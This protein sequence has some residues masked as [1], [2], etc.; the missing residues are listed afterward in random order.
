MILGALISAGLPVE[1]LR[2]S[3]SQL[4]V[5]NFSISTRQVTKRGIRA[6]YLQVISKHDKRKH[7]HIK[8]IKRILKESRISSQVKDRAMGI[9]NN[10]AEAEARVH[11]VKK[12][13]I[14]FHELGAVDT[15]VDIVGSVIGIDFFGIDAVY[16]SDLP[17]GRGSVDIRHGKFPLP[18]PAVVELLKGV[19]VRGVDTER[20]LVTP[21]GAA[22]LK[23]LAAGFGKIPEMMIERTGYGAGDYDDTPLPD[24]LRVLIGKGRDLNTC[25]WVLETNID[26][27]NPQL[28][29]STM[30]AL[31]K[32]GALD[33]FITPVIMKKSRPGF[34]LTVLVE[35]KKKERVEE[36]IFQ[37]TTT[38][39]IRSYPVE[40]RTLKRMEIVKKIGGVD[41]CFKRSYLSGKIVNETPEY[42]DVK[43]FAIKNNI[44]LK[45]A[46]MIIAGKK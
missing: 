43:R 25:L 11:G 36:L 30:E 10:L 24:V 8:D 14:E 20:E 46:F 3:L 42:E 37:N 17:L 6:V 41:I 38:I 16:S 31:F 35:E 34:L 23:T 2:R 21:T 33:V 40:R 12:D 28:F 45:E 4:K 9:L 27:M 1:E 26:D 39:G 29:E 15:I 13:E 7:V 18:A 5:N 44:P 32:E 19:P 22:I